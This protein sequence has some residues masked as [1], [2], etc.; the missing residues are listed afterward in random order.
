MNAV[1]ELVAELERAGLEVV[2]TRG[3]HLRVKGRTGCY[4]MAGTPSDHRALAN[5]RAALKRRGMLP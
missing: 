5:A 2:R 3:G 4:F 1:R